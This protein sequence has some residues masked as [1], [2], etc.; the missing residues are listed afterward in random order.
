[1]MIVQ[2]N[3]LPFVSISRSSCINRWN[4]NQLKDSVMYLQLENEKVRI[5]PHSVVAPLAVSASRGIAC[6]FAARKRALVYVLD[7]DEDDVSDTE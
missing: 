5:I 1:M 4:L 6:V 3:D 7:E 2:A